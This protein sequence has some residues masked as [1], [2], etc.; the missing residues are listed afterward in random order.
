MLVFT[1]LSNNGVILV[2]K[3]N[4]DRKEFKESRDLKEKRERLD[5]A[6]NLDCL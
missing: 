2:L 5:K 6:S 4:R 3:V 1:L